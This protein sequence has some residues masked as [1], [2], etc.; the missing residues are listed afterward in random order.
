M[1][2]GIPLGDLSAPVL[3]GIAFLLVMFGRLVPWWLYKEKCKEAENW[4]AAYEKE[5]A[6]RDLS[7]AQKTELLEAVKITNDILYAMFDI[8]TEDSRPSGGRHRV[9]PTSH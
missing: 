7:E 5:R 8:T 9:V 6:S 2:D 3:V 1:F 4:Q